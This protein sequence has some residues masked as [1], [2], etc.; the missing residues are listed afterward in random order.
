[1]KMVRIRLARPERQECRKVTL[2]LS[3]STDTRL[4]VLAEVRK[5]DRSAIAEQILSE[6]LAGINVE[7]PEDLAPKKVAAA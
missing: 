2:I 5:T 4:G 7:V 6:A 1:M 3:A